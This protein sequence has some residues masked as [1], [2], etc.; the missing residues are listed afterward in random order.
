MHTR[1]TILEFYCKLAAAFSVLVFVLSSCIYVVFL[2]FAVGR[3][4]ER[5]RAEASI[6]EVGSELGG[7]QAQYIAATQT[8]T[9]ERAAA[10]GFVRPE[11]SAVIYIDDT[12]RTFSLGAK[13]QQDH[14]ATSPQ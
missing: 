5:A 2:L 13:P 1:A 3:T 12:V 6:K 9:P 10:L 4:E 11:P 8:V 7:I 14:A